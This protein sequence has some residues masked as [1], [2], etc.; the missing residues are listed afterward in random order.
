MPDLTAPAA[1]RRLDMPESVP[2]VGDLTVRGGERQLEKAPA[3]PDL[4]LLDATYANTHV[5]PPPPYALKAFDEAASGAGMTYTPYV[6]DRG[7][8]EHVATNVN[9]EFGIHTT[10]SA[11]VI[12]TPGTQSALFLA[13]SAIVEPGD[14]VVLPDPDYLSTERTLR[15]LGAAVERVPLIQRADGYADLDRD[16]LRAVCAA[17]N[18]KL[19][20]FSNPNNPTGAVYSPETLELIAEEAQSGD[21]WVLAD[22]LYCRLVYDTSYYGHLSTFE[23]MQHRT[24]TTLGPSKT[25]SLSGY[26]LGVGVAPTEIIE[27]MEDIQSIAALRAPAYA[28]HVLS[29]WIA[30]DRDYVSDR[31]AQ[32]AHLRDVTVEILNNSGLFEVI[33]SRGTSYLFPKVLTSAST[34]Q[35]ALALKE[36][37]GV[38]VNPG[39]QFGPR[40]DGHIR[41]CIAQDESVW[42]D[43][44]E[45]MIQTVKTL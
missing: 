20:I 12:L 30:E 17:S 4:E 3:A 44:L 37:A 9:E 39:Y 24:I 18:V 29:H 6:G 41:L 45:R 42:R 33:A 22:E 38:V 25:E 1:V 36:Q 14:T 32:Y 40:G 7:V 13:L 23:G 34:Q 28:Q 43:R 16:I 8:I 15:Y 21:F 35:V 2:Y 31:I 19:L 27:R 5:F 10:G 26:R 11:G